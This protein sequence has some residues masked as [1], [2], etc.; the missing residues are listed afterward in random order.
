MKNSKT[1]K[2][3]HNEIDVV[4]TLRQHHVSVE[5]RTIVM[6][7]QQQVGIRLWGKID[8]LRTYRGYNLVTQK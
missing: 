2:Q 6:H 4:A 8:Y 1:A 3:K 7:K 5:N